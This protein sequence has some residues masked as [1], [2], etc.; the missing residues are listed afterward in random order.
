[1]IE[2]R[3]FYGRGGHH[4]GTGAP[5][6][7]GRDGSGSRYV[8][9]CKDCGVN[10]FMAENIKTGNWCPVDI[11]GTYDG[12]GNIVFR[13]Q[14]VI[15]CEVLTKEDLASGMHWI[16]HMPHQATCAAISRPVATA[17]EPDS[18]ERAALPANV[19]PF[20]SRSTH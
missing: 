7:Q 13:G 4:G 15:K 3:T 19:I 6:H 11:P 20:P 10:I 8:T 5:G 12:H 9:R 2:V 17:P 1:M 16:R 18:P 14:A